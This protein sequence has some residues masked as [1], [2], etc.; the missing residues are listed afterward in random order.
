[1]I[2]FTIRV[3]SVI[4]LRVLLRWAEARYS[5]EEMYSLWPCFILLM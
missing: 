4:H 3:L 2:K 5:T 1:M